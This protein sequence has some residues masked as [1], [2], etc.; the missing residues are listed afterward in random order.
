MEA[1]NL[2]T[3]RIAECR[4]L[5][6]TT[7]KAADRLK[8]AASRDVFD[9]VHLKFGENVETYEEFYVILLNRANRVLGISKISEGGISGTVADPKKI[10]QTALKAHACSIILS[11]NHTSGNTQPSENDIRLTKKL[12]EGGKLLDLP[13]LDHVIVAA[14]TYYSF[15]DEGLI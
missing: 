9:L 12:V 14:D 10:F 4:I 13:V 1:P 8:L 11:H 15:A 6:N 3:Q 7:V 5:W 2:F